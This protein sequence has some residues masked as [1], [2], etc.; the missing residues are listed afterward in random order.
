MF[1][2]GTKLR[3]SGFKKKMCFGVIFLNCVLEFSLP[4]LRDVGQQPLIRF[5]SNWYTIKTL[6]LKN[7]SLKDF[8]MRPVIRPELRIAACVLN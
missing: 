7:S 4:N 2:R 5:P 1:L 8:T 6:Y 3:N